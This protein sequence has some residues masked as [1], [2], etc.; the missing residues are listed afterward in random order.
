MS[1][2]ETIRRTHAILHD[3]GQAG[4]GGALTRD[5]AHILMQNPAYT[6][7]R[8]PNHARLSEV[9]RQHFAA[10]TPNGNERITG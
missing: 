4:G 3:V 8:D 9:L 10:T 5:Q 1:D 7:P 2:F 6:D